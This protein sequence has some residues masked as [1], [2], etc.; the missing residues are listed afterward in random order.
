[1][2]LSTRRLPFLAGL[3]LS[4][5]AA[6]C[7][8]ADESE[9]AEAIVKSDQALV[10]DS[11]GDATTHENLVSP[12]QKPL[13]MLGSAG[14]EVNGL[15][16]HS[17]NTNSHNPVNPPGGAGSVPGGLFLYRSDEYML[18]WLGIRASRS[19]DTNGSGWDVGGA[20][21]MV[22]GTDYFSLQSRGLEQEGDGTNKWNSDFGAGLIGGLHGL[23]IPEMYAELAYNDV[24]TKLGKFFH[25]LGY[26]RYT[27][28]GDSI[29]NTRS[30]GAIYGEFAT[31]TGTQVD[32]QPNE[33]F[34][35]TAA[36]HRGDANWNDN[37]NY[38][39][40][41]YGFNWTSSDGNTELR[42]MFDVGR[43]DNAGLEDQYIHAIVLQRRFTDRL[44]YLLHNNLGWVEGNASGRGDTCWYSIEQQLAY[45]VSDKVVVGFRYEWFDDIDGGRVDPTP[46]PGVYH[47]FDVGGTYRMTEQVWFRPELRWD[48]FAAENNAAP[49]PFGNS[50]ERSQ[51]LGSFSMFMFF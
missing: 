29:G 21:H 43:E 39:S 7:C 27:P 19:V 4:G 23:A 5:L 40:S 11:L 31:V 45:E 6:A 13:G 3:L 41:Y 42:Y 38:W 9:I 51:F 46:G 34:I 20:I 26:S 28:N 35:L 18:N 30:Y 15:L 37:N 2:R 24:T 25:P 44:Q 12:T 16:W 17:V 8:P 14:I 32:W 48:W 22:Y 49:G 10:C 50:T 47:L 36:L 1:M 33:Q